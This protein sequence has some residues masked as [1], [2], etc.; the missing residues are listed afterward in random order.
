MI[1]DE[2]SNPN[3]YVSDKHPFEVWDILEAWELEL[4]EGTA[5]AYIARAK[6]K[7]SRIA[8]LKKAVAWLNRKIKLLE[9]ETPVFSKMAEDEN[10]T[11]KVKFSVGPGLPGD[12][13]SYGVP[14]IKMNVREKKKIKSTKKKK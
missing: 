3:H 5:V 9:G 7:G 8:D 14:Y 13:V 12:E 2:I 6:K 10:D 4:H 1:A 11:V